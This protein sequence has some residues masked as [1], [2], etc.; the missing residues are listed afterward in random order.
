MGEEFRKI[1][2][3][4]LG[5][6]QLRVGDQVREVFWVILSVLWT[7]VCTA[8]SVPLTHLGISEKSPLRE[9]ARDGKLN[10]G[11]PSMK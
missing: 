8:V 11:M 9:W 10:F 3:R 4:T 6:S 7:T 1:L 5:T 2:C